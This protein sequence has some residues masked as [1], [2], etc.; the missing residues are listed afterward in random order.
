[1]SRKCKMLIATKNSRGKKKQL[2]KERG[3]ESIG[4]GRVAFC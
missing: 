2:V 4:S 3:E 1:M